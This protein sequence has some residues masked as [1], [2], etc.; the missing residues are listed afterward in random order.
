MK[1]AYFVEWFPKL[2]ETF[3]QRE[4]DGLLEHGIEIE[5]FPYALMPR[6]PP[7]FAFPVRYG[8]GAR[9]LG[10][11]GDLVRELRLHRGLFRE[12][13]R[14][15]RP[16]VAMRPESWYMTV[17]G[18][19]TALRHAENVRAGDYRLLHA[20]WAHGPANVGSPFGI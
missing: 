7:R 19:L 9:I 12:A 6:R 17:M 13:L 18:V 11:P 2:S 3:I 1:V 5:V 15:L 20:A 8:G 10:L 4:I 16:H 14:L